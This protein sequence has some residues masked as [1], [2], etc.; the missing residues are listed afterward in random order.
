MSTR[1]LRID[2][3]VGHDQGHGW[4]IQR[5]T[6]HGWTIHREDYSPGVESFDQ[7]SQIYSNNADKATVT[8]PYYR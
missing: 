1:S 3:Q 6:F 8:T 5:R 4:T 7:F 2:P